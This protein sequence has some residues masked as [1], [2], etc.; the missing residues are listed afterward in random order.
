MHMKRLLAAMSVA[1]TFGAGGVAAAPAAK[2][3]APL[4]EEVWG[5]VER[6]LYDPHFAGQD[7]KAVGARYRARLG[8]ARDDAGFA[9]L[10]NAMLGELKLSHLYLNMPDASRAAGSTGIGAEMEEV[11]GERVVVEVVPLSAAQRAG[12]RV[13]DRIRNPKALTGALGAETSLEVVGCDGVARTVTTRHERATWPPARPA[14]SWRQVTVRPGV[15]LGYI[16]IDRFDDGAADF[17]D[18]AMADLKDTQGL[19][20][21]VRRNSGGNLSALRLASYFIEGSRPAVALAIR[22]YLQGLGRPFGAA[23]MGA[24][25]PVRGAYTDAGVGEAIQAGKGAAAYYSEDLGA[26]RYRGKVVVVTSNATGSAGEG[27]AAMMRDLANAPSVGQPTAGY[28]LSSE[29]Y[30]L[31]GGWVLTIPTSGVW[32]PDARDYGDKPV[33]PTVAIPRGAADFCRADD[34]DLSAATDLLDRQIGR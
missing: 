22:P 30:K 15:T 29:R 31:A 23:D 19:V 5:T 28:I 20:I 18:L 13:G 2:P 9:R 3:Y 32:G 6:E 11:G 33:Q 21:D 16:R 26:K 24:L 25:T 1:I 12:L 14:F 34:P 7:W 8:E 10:A 17:A 27:F 4:F